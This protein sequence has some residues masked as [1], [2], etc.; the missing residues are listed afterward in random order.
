MI[1]KVF[2]VLIGDKFIPLNKLDKNDF[3]RI[4]DFESIDWRV[5]VIRNGGLYKRDWL[6]LLDN[7]RK[8]I[9]TKLNI[10]PAKLKISE[11]DYDIIA[12]I[13]NIEDE[14]N[15][16]ASDKCGRLSDV[17]KILFEH[18]SNEIKTELLKSRSSPISLDDIEYIHLLVF[19]DNITIS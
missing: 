11:N 17:D 5:G 16:F 12:K 4:S 1:K 18:L 13:V 14:F 2:R 19:L 10:K 9:K 7:E 3:D 15:F 6:K 8:G